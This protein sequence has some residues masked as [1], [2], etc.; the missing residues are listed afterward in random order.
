MIATLAP[1]NQKKLKTIFKNAYAHWVTGGCTELC[2]T[3]QV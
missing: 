2:P 3:E 1:K